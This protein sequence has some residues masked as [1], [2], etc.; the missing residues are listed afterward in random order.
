M[1]V[2]TA[3]VQPPVKLSAAERDRRWSALTDLMR[4]HDLG[5]VIGHSDQG[6]LVGYQRWL[7]SYRSIFGDLASLVFADGDGA[8]VVSNPAVVGYAKSLSWMNDVSVGALSKAWLVGDTVEAPVTTASSIGGELGRRVRHRG[9]TRVGLADAERFPS[10]WRDAIAA[11]VPGCCFVDLREDIDRLRLV[12]SAEEIAC[13]R[14]SCQISDR[15]W[16]R[17]PQIVQPGRRECE[18]MADFEG[19]IRAEGAEETYNMCFPLP[20]FVH[21]L[22]SSPSTRV[23]QSGDALTIEISPRWSGYFGQQ[24]GLVSLGKLKSEMREAY[25]AIDRAREAGLRVM[26]PGADLTDVTA[27]VAKQFA[28]DGH[29]LASPLIGHFVGLELE[30]PRAGAKPQKLEPGMVFIFHPFSKGWPAL[31]RADTFLITDVGV[32]RMTTRSTA[33]LEL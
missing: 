28:A 5:V 1:N 29:E 21:P 2:G 30:E 10:G 33:P 15:V 8:M 25:A 17:M 24:T 31:M 11:A 9:I 13:I 19:M 6:D 27:A 4:E 18:V 20:I 16:G 14:T 22:E 3:V 7:S 26:R 12:K 32:E 23:I